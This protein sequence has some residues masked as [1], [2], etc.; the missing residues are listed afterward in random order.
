MSAPINNKN[1]IKN[2]WCIIKGK[3]Q[4]GNIQY[5][6]SNNVMGMRT[7]WYPYDTFE[8]AKSRLEEIKLSIKK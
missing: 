8:D 5:Q 6:V 1:A 2:R 3:S 7:V 4:E